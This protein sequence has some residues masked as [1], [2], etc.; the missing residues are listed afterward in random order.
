MPT[1]ILKTEPSTYSF[2]DLQRE[3]RAVWDG[4]SNPAALAFLRGA[5][6]GDE[7]M[8][9][10]TGDEKAI[11]GLARITSDAYEDPAQP[12]S[13]ADGLPKVP[14]VDLAP[15]RPAPRPVTLAQIKAD[16][17]FASF[18]LVRQ[19]RLSVIPVPPDLEAALRELA[20]F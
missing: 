3:K 19:P 6:R 14:V 18:P 4:I 20:G 9:Y 12:G 1:F 16:R 11:V 15:L 7:A 8:I 17:R 2:A 10:H 13:N 5:R